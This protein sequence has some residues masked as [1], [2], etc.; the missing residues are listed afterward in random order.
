[1]TDIKISPSILSADFANLGRDLQK[2]STAGADYIH[3][4]VMDGSF[5][6]NLTFGKTIL[7]NLHKTSTLQKPLFIDT[8]RTNTCCYSI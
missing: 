7:K 6:P 8:L 5:V 2:I 1:M 3:L 4:D